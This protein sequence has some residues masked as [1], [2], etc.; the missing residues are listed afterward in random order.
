MSNR[1][2]RATDKP[3][4]LTH[5]C[6]F[7]A[8]NRYYCI[9]ADVV[10]YIYPSCEV[11]PLPHHLSSI[12]GVFNL[13]GA[14]IPVIDMGYKCEQNPLSLEPEHKFIIIKVSGRTL[15]LHVEEVPDILPVDTS[16]YNEASQVLPGLHVLFG[17]VQYQE[18]L[19]LVYDPEQF[20]HDE[21]SESVVARRTK[22]IRSTRE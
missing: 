14:T 6:V 9:P 20:F 5:V 19:A 16:V 22:K 17:V 7:R 2:E 1:I 15:A 12:Q 11:T 3:A 8:G 21:L 10:E 4:T 13:H 18:G